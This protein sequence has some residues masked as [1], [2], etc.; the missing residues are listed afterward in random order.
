MMKYGH[1]LLLFEWQG[2]SCFNCWRQGTPYKTLTRSLY[3]VHVDK[4]RAFENVNKFLKTIATSIDIGIENGRLHQ[5]NCFSAVPKTN[6]I[7]KKLYTIADYSRQS[8]L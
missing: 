5:L 1:M 6:N 8:S 3:I 7:L 4:H 2:I